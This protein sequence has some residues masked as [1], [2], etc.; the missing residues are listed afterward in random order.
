MAGGTRRSTTCSSAY[1]T[2]DEHTAITTSTAASRAS[3][4]TGL[5]DA[6][7]TGAQH[8]PAGRHADGEPGDAA[9][10]AR[11]RHPTAEQ[12]VR[13]PSTPRR[14]RWPPDRPPRRGHRSRLTPASSTTPDGG[15]ADPRTVA[16]AR[17]R[18]RGHRHRAQ[19]LDRHGRAQRQVVDADVERHVHQG[20]RRRRTVPAVRSPARVQATR[21]GRRHA[22]STTAAIATRSHA[23]VAGGQLVEQTDRQGRTDVLGQARQDEDQRRGHRVRLRPSRHRQHGRGHRTRSRRMTRPAARARCT[24]RSPGPSGRSD[25]DQPLTAPASRPRTK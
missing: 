7:K 5:A 25:G 9:G 18:R 16:P 3:C 24:A 11:R 14:C 12:D 19:E 13:P 1:G 21:H 17:A 23:T 4:S 20:E 10:L 8:Q 6:A 2:T 15:Q 22:T